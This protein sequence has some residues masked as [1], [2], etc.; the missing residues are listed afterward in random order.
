MNAMNKSLLVL[1]GVILAISG[2]TLAPSYKTPEAPVPEAWPSEPAYGSVASVSG[3]PVSAEIPW[4]EFFVDRQMQKVIE[5]ALVNNRDLRLAALNVQRARAIFGIQRSAIYP[6]VDVVANG[7]KQRTPADLTSGGEV[8]YPEKYDVGLGIFA[9]EIDFFGRIRSLKD[10]ALES[11]LATAQARRSTQILVVSAVADAY[12]ALAADREN[13]ALSQTTL[14]AQRASYDLIKRRYEVGLSSELDLN[15][16]ETQVAVARR[17]IAGY[18]LRVAQDI[19]A[20]RLLV[21][22]LE[23]LPPAMLPDGLAGVKPPQPIY[24][25]I[26]SDA[27]LL[28]PDILQAE[29]LLKAANANIGAARAALFPRISL[30]TSLGTASSQLS[31]LFDSG[32]GTWLFAPKIAMPIFDA[33]LWSAVDAAKAENDI[34]LVQYEKAVQTAFR[35]VADAL[36]VQGTIDERLAAQQSL[37]DAASKTYRLSD[38]RYTKGIDNYLS[39]LD[40]QRSLFS[41][42]QELVALKF[43]KISNQV[44]LYA[45]LGGGAE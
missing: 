9:W 43:E 29:N 41:A 12:L 11:F 7:S 44:R 17:N 8:D 1:L 24:A 13:L 39:V 5:T 6:A 27:L 19:N 3:A 37:V 4:R 21:G 38:M 2:C 22:S 42:Q 31:G 34:A 36:A 26:S 20:L 33:R 45:V 23:Q 15:R 35:E 32:S 30:T 14:D 16:A 40:A 28:R 10:Q 18:T 25:G